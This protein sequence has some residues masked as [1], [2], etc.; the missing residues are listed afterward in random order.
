[1]TRLAH[2]VWVDNSCWTRQDLPR[3]SGTD[4]NSH[5]GYFCHSSVHKLALN[6]FSKACLL[7]AS[8]HVDG[9]QESPEELKDADFV[10]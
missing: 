10:L 2:D 9:C 7:L 1:M 6:V 8:V 5:S 4:P 3:P